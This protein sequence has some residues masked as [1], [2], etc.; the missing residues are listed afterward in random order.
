MSI[1][2]AEEFQ[3]FKSSPVA[4]ANGKQQAPN[5]QRGL[6]ILEHLAKLPGGLTVTQLSELLGFPTASVFRIVNV[7]DE[8]G[9]LNRDPHSKKFFLTNRFLLMGKP[10]GNDK[11]LSECCLKSM[12]NIR[13]ATGET[14]QL[15]C[16]VGTEMVMLEQLISTHP[17][18]YSADLGARCPCY[19]TAPGKAIAA[20]FP[21]EEQVEL[22]NAIHFKKFT[23]TTITSKKQFSK[24]L[25]TIRATGF[26]VDR[27]EGLE[28]IHCVAAPIFDEHNYPVAAITIAGP[29]SRIPADEF[30][31]I[32]SLI[33]E[34]AH[35]ATRE[36]Q[37]H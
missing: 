24:E 15:C 30:E 25:A 12:R 2:A 31:T 27:A 3:Q 4:N 9:Y 10:Q 22:V 7:L 21:D 16:L 35:E 26:A 28:G 11:S 1:H 23:K 14:T 29:A 37:H 32:G 18:K 20:F 6:A 34:G 8:L 17:F 19:S 5:L 13:K 36:F 33:C